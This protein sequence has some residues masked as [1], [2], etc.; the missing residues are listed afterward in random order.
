MAGFWDQFQLHSDGGAPYEA[1][2]ITGQPS[3]DPSQLQIQPG[4]ATT[5]PMTPAQTTPAPTTDWNQQTFSQQ[6]GT[7]GTPQE[8][9]ALEPRLNQAGIKVLRNAAGVAG[10]IQLPDGS[11]VDVINS[12]GAGGTGFQWLTGGG[13]G[14][15]IGGPGSG[16]FVAPFVPPSY[17]DALKDPGTLIALQRGQQAIQNSA[18]ARGTLLSGGTLKALNDYAMGTAQQ[19]Y[20]S[21]FDRAYQTHVRNE[22]APFDKFYK[23]SDLGQRSVAA[24]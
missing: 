6:F 1:G 21:V 13:S 20:Q 7:P 14:S 24:S 2:G 9:A 10:K 18:A 11:I 3:V 12:A 5:M 22:D 15:A 23:L 4:G 16:S 8:L 19:G 17:E